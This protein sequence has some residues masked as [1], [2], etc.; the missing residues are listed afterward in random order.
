MK[1]VLPVIYDSWSRGNRDILF[2]QTKK[3]ALVAADASHVFGSVDNGQI[4]AWFGDITCFSFDGI[5]NITGVE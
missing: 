3:N 2:F 5:K 1:V 4:V